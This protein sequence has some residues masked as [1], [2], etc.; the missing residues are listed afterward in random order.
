MGPPILLDENLEHEILHRLRKYGHEAE[1]IDFHDSLQK[2]DEDGTLAK[3]S[4]ENSVLLVTYD[5]DFATRYDESDYWGV[6]LLTDNDWSAT[7]VADTV[8]RILTLYSPPALQQM[9]VVGREWL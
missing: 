5:D 3:Y 4:L 6:L 8:H 9:N 7:D 1:H 2:G